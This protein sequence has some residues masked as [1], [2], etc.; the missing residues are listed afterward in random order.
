MF[1]L[2]P[3]GFPWWCHNILTIA[4]WELPPL[5]TGRAPLTH[6]APRQHL[7]TAGALPVAQVSTRDP[8]LRPASAQVDP[9][10]GVAAF[11]PPEL[12]GFSGTMQ[13]SDF[14]AAICLPC[15]FSLSGI[16]VLSDKSNRD[17]TG[18][19][20]DV[21]CS[22]NGPS[23]PGLPAPLAKTRRSMLPSS[24]RKPWAGSDRKQGF[25][26]SIPFTA[27]QPTRSVHPH[28]LSVY[29]S[30]CL[31]PATLQHSILGLWLGVTQAGF[32]PARHQ[33]ISSPHT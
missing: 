8:A 11:P 22:A 24:L 10:T 1:S 20:G 26:S 3:P 32:P 31:L 5:R 15:F 12:P 25:R 19:L 2:L 18:C 23:T 28:Y 16:L 29:A 4:N 21:M 13:R 33:T 17:L 14:P 7:C 6:P 27:G 9:R 30:T